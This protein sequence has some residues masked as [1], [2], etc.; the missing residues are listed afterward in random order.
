MNWVPVTGLA[1]SCP[2]PEG[3]SNLQPFLHHAGIVSAQNWLK[4]EHLCGGDANVLAKELEPL[5]LIVILR[6]QETLKCYISLYSARSACSLTSGQCPQVP[7]AEQ[8][9]VT[10]LAEVSLP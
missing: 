7:G 4:V 2:S 8:G 5:W 10:V 1:D 3:A 9:I 6:V